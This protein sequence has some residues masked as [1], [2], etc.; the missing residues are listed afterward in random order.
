VCSSDLSGGRTVQDPDT[1]PDMRPDTRP[2]TSG[3]TLR[4]D[5][6]LV[7]VTWRA[8]ALVVPASKGTDYLEQLVAAPGREIH[9][10]DL[11]GDDDR[12]D[13]GE[14]IDTAARDAYRERAEDLRGE[15][16]LARDRNDVGRA[17]RLGE[18]LDALAE[19]LAAGVGLGGRS[20]RAASRVERARINVQRRI[21]DAIRRLAAEDDALGRYLDATVATGT[22]CSFTPLA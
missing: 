21:R 17:A 6:A 3:F 4:R 7:H 5:G 19:Q 15:L 12:G 18:E 10:A 14:V 9:V 16:Q 1:R 13:A 20:R 22:F 11:V 2:D 8:R